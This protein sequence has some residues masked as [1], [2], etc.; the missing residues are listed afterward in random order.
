MIFVVVVAFSFYK[1]TSTY[2]PHYD[3]PAITLVMN[4]ESHAIVVCG[5]VCIS[6][7]VSTIA[8]IV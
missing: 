3:R 8:V 1:F 7:F 4:T 2:T 5:V 6:C